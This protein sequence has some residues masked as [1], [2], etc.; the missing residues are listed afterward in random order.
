VPTYSYGCPRCGPFDLVRPMAESGADATCSHCGAAARRAFG[1]PALRALSR[2]ATAALEKG[3]RSAEAPEVVSTVP[4]AGR[5]SRSRVRYT[6]DPRH[7][8]LPRP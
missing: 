2:E 3:E 5:A 7:A 4:A 6:R 8:L 1:A